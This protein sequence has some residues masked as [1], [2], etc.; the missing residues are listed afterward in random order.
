M[1]VF[2]NR[3]EALLSLALASFFLAGS[4]AAWAHQRGPYAVDELFVLDLRGDSVKLEYL[5]HLAEVPTLKEWMQIDADE[6][7]IVTP[8][9]KAAYVEKRLP[10]LLA[11]LSVEVA[12]TPV[13]LTAEGARAETIINELG[14]E[15]LQVHVAARAAWPDARGPSAPYDASVG[16]SLFPD[17]NGL[18]EVTL[19]LGE[20]FQT[21][22]AQ[23]GAGLQ[24]GISADGSGAYVFRNSEPHFSFR[25]EA[26]SAIRTEDTPEAAARAPGDARLHEHETGGTWL[27]QIL[28]ILER[29]DLTLTTFLL[30]LLIAAAMGMGHAWSPGHGKTIMA[31]YLIG[32]RGT[33]WHAVLLGLTVTV[34]HTWSVFLLGL[35]T[36]AAG[37]AISEDRLTFWTGL[38]SGAIIAAIGMF[39][40]VRRVRDLRAFRARDTGGLEHH[41]HHLH[42]HSHDH[43]THHHHHDHGHSHPHAREGSPGYGGILWLG[44]SGGIVPCPAALI[45]LL[46]AIKLGQLSYGLALIAAF[47]FGL[48][49]V[50]VGLGM[51]VVRGARM[52]RTGIGARPAV[53]VVLPVVSSALIT[54]LGGGVVFWTLVQYGII[55]PGT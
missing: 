17:K 7:G 31:A 29:K 46:L 55:A 26:A 2:G 38:A 50:L 48:A 54:I 8:E 40:F 23:R 41:H 44:V 4:S 18:F 19:L 11:G 43:A 20:S 15:E 42:H 16:S 14:L 24:E 1:F 25:V 37:S 36:L 53:A 3:R 13:R 28:T 30:G 10:G 22:L 12:G 34:T 51:A 33:Y 39:L 6:D 27:R 52:M 21:S 47:S 9:E 32:E 35:L 45:V 49:I 5:A